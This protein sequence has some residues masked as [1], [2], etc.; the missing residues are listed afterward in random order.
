VIAQFF[1]T[2][3]FTDDTDEIEYWQVALFFSSVLSVQSVVKHLRFESVEFLQEFLKVGPRPQRS[4]SGLL[5]QCL[6]IVEPS[7]DGPAEQV[8]RRVLGIAKNASGRLG[9]IASIHQSQLTDGAGR[10]VKLG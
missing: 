2:T 3:D 9:L 8:N 6:P 4:E 1:S 10:G 5:F 7:G